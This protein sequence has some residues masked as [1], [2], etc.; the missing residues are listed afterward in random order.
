MEIRKAYE[1]LCENDIL[2]EEFKIFERKGLTCA[3]DFPTMFKIEWIKI[4]LSR[5][6]NGSLRM[7]DGPIR[8]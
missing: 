7:E 3:L 8:I 4:V 1:K 5:I 2:K 6:H